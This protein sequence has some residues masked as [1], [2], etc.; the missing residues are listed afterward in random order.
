MFNSRCEPALCATHQK[1]TI[2]SS[3]RKLLSSIITKYYHYALPELPIAQHSTRSIVQSRHSV[4]LP[5]LQPSN[6]KQ[7]KYFSSPPFPTLSCQQQP[8]CSL[9]RGAGLC[10]LCACVCVHNCTARTAR[11]VLWISLHWRPCPLSGTL[12]PPAD[13]HCEHVGSLSSR[14][15]I[16]LSAAFFMPAEGGTNKTKS[17]LVTTRTVVKKSRVSINLTFVNFVW[18]EKKELQL[19]YEKALLFLLKICFHLCD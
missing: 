1:H 13:L 5:A 10:R 15:M 11:M 7:K 18:N 16:T 14:P 4:G 3:S 9:R 6:D 12:R 17:I 2:H 19:H 8:V